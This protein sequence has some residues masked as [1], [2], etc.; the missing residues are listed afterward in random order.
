MVDVNDA[1]REELSVL[2]DFDHAPSREEIEERA[3]QITELAKHYQE[4]QG[5]ERAMIGGAPWLM[6]VLESALY[7]ARIEP[8]YAFSLRESAEVT[9]PDGSVKKTLVFRH[10][11]FVYPK[12]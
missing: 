1:D 8:V 9:L 5:M 4:E 10:R 3:R 2:L 7:K 11:G 12:S 6:A